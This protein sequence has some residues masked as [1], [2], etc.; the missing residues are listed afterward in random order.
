[1]TR[2]FTLIELLV[3]IAIIAILAA[4]LFPVF[5]RA[6]EK[7]RQSSCLSNIKQITTASIMYIQDYDE[8]LY[9][10]RQGYRFP[11]TDWGILNWPQ[12]LYPYVMNEQ[13][14]TCPS[15]ATGTWS[16]DADPSTPGPTRD[17]DFG[18]GM[19]YWM[20]YA[21]YAPKLADFPHPAETIWFTDCNYYIVYPSYY[22]NRYPDNAT[23]GLEGRARLQNRHNQGAN[24]GFLDGHAKWL[25]DS[26]L[27]GDI[28]GTGSD[29]MWWGGSDRN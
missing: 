19:N 1:M 22:L 13:L 9:G 5:A 23:Y 28:G 11:E 20:T 27:E 2:G 6:R 10:H 29:S 21:Y 12:Q 18:Y 15:H 26:V 14:F 3:V 4:I 7:A 8:T 16:Y 17:N 24:V 25:S